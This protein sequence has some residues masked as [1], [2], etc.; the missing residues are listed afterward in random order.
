MNQKVL[1]GIAI[2]V[3]LVFIF[4][5]PVRAKVLITPEGS[6]ILQAIATIAAVMIPMILLM[7]PPAA[8]LP[9][10]LMKKSASKMPRRPQ[11]KH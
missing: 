5:A 6:I 2:S 3:L 9:E 8:D 11:R 7:I 10:L 4:A 1:A